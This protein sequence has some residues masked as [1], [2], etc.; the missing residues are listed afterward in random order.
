MTSRAKGTQTRKTVAKS[1]LNKEN[2]AAGAGSANFKAKPIPKWLRGIIIIVLVIVVAA[3]LIIGISISVRTNNDKETFKLVRATV[4]QESKNI[5]M[6]VTP[7]LDWGDASS[8][9]FGLGEANV[10]NLWECKADY[11][12]SIDLSSSSTSGYTQVLV[13]SFQT[14]TNLFTFQGQRASDGF[15]TQINSYYVVDAT[16]KSTN[17]SCSL[18]IERT[19]SSEP[20]TFSVDLSCSGSALQ[21]WY[22]NSGTI[23]QTAPGSNAW[24]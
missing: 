19:S 18:V 5:S 16:D 22:P 12:S 7:V 4:A 20:G 21:S 17:L 23:N 6:S 24:K 9:N 8:C 13:K 14:A 11:T 15:P 2:K 3:I 1:L 10:N